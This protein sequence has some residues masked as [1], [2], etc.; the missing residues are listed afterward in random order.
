[1]NKENFLVRLWNKTIF[2]DWFKM[3]KEKNELIRKIKHK[4]MITAIENSENELIEHYKNKEIEKIK[5]GGDNIFKKIGNDLANSGFKLP[6]SDKIGNAFGARNNN[7]NNNNNEDKIT[8]MLGGNN[9]S[10]N[11]NNE[12]KITRMLGGSDKFNQKKITEMLKNGKNK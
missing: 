10:N 1:M 8:R 5:N 11:N 9:N 2:S 12:D 6:S 4:A 3:R 7:S